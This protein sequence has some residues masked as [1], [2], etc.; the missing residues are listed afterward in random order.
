MTEANKPA[1][2][3][4]YD[5]QESAEETYGFPRGPAF[6]EGWRRTMS[7]PFKNA[8]LRTGRA[9]SAIAR[10]QRSEYVS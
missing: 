9:G 7:V 1:M 2:P 3:P 8:V 10:C 4:A 5:P 6:P